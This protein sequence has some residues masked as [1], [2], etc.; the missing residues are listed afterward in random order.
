V[1]KQE[2]CFEFELEKGEIMDFKECVVLV[3]GAGAGIGRA[4]ATAFTQAGSRVM[5]NDLVRA[6]VEE[7]GALLRPIAA[8]R[9]ATVVADVRVKTEI[10]VMVAETTRRLGPIDILINNA[11]ICPSS[12]VIEMPVEEWDAVLAT[13]LRG[14][15]LLCQ[16]VARQMVDRGKGGKI[17]NI[18]SGAYKSA[19]RGAAHY[20]ASK[21]GLEMFTKV[22]ALELGEHHINVNA[23]A[24]GLTDTGAVADTPEQ[25]RDTLVKAIP[26]GRM[27]RPEE[28][29]RAVLFLASEE[30][31]YITGETLLVDGG[32]LAGRYFLPASGKRR[33]S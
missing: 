21:S 15:F 28:I 24:P 29:A 3:T 22:L 18:T 16:V 19:R 12:P 4:I 1:L 8:D 32:S 13:N 11:G 6:N 31:E 17:I 9:I 25:Y 20:C 30:S 27:G 5:A 10:D 26:W 33:T 23:V 2:S 14:P 7:T